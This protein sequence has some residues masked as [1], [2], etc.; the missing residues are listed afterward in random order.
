[1]PH[2]SWSGLH[3]RTDHGLRVIPGVDIASLRRHPRRSQTRLSC[4]AMAPRCAHHVLYFLGSN[5]AFREAS[6]AFSLSMNL[7]KHVH[8]LVC[9]CGLDVVLGSPQVPAGKLFSHV[10]HVL[11]CLRVFSGGKWGCCQD[12]LGQ[13]QAMAESTS[14]DKSF[15]TAR[16]DATLDNA[17][18]DSSRPR[19]R[20]RQARP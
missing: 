20:S 13:R 12:A 8:T 6:C 4:Q 15:Q 17:F 14:N 11:C 19:D 7:L 3:A 5:F 10:Y 2:I 18:G 9:G 1:V 16:E